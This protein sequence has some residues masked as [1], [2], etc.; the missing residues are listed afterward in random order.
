MGNWRTLGS[1]SGITVLYWLMQALS[2][3]AL[4]LSYDMDLSVWHAWAV[5]LI[6]SIGTAIPSAP[7][8]LGVFQSVVK[9]ALTIFNVEPG[10]ALELSVLMWAAMTLPLLIAGLAAVFLTGSSLKEI[11]HHARHR[12]QPDPKS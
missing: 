3:W 11:H 9:L 8:N 7:G 5:T 4:L 6:K 2:V 10:V 1:A 12:L